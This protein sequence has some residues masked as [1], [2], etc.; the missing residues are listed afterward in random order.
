MLNMNICI[1]N[2][3]LVMLL[4]KLKLKPGK[5]EDRRNGC[6]PP[7]DSIKVTGGCGGG[8][9]LYGGPVPPSAK[10]NKL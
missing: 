3:G 2:K 9:E 7:W 8:G 5:R 1:G 6:N 4:P 10:Q